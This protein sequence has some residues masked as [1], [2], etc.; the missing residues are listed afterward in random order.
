MVDQFKII[1]IGASAGGVEALVQLMESIPHD[2]N[3][4][5]LVVMHVPGS[6]Q[7]ALPQILSRTN[8]LAATYPVDG[9]RLQPGRIYV[10]P[11]NWHMLVGNDGQVIH[12]TNGPREHS[13]R[14]AID[15]LFR[16]AAA[17]VKSRCIG[18]ILSGMLDD[19]TA[20]LLA[21][22]QM[23]G[24]AIVQDPKSSLFPSM[25]QSAIDHVAVDFIKPPAAIGPLLGELCRTP[26]SVELGENKIVE[27][28]TAIDELKAEPDASTL[29][30]KSSEFA[31]P[32]CAGV[33]WAI[34]EESGDVR[35]RCRVGHAYSATTLIDSQAEVFEKALWSAIRALREKA[36]LSKRVETSLR[37][38]NRH[39]MA[40]RYARDA[41]KAV[42]EAAHLISMIDERKMQQ[43]G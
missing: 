2:L 20:G 35:Y 12:L 8:R 43:Q 42:A 36:D 16:S 21:I 5:V 32:E 3:A 40:D 17:H 37:K 39:S 10:A 6:A 34:S 11:P 38:K 22:K 13:C 7:S 28:E 9:Q 23:G 31:C 14:P 18:V 33:L 19:G 29:L 27:T 26:G 30:G 4:A 25:P 24:T 1:V 41:D 15:P